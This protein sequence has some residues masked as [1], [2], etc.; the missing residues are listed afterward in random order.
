M[1]SVRNIR[2]IHGSMATPSGLIS[3]TPVA[4]HRGEGMWQVL[5]MFDSKHKLPLRLFSL[6]GR[7]GLSPHSSRRRRCPAIVL[8]A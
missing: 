6:S 8:E 1:L 3:I 5:S 2:S 7:Q 4:D